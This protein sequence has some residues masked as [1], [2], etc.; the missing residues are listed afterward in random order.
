VA[1]YFGGRWLGR[2]LGLGGETAAYAGA[3]LGV[4]AG[5]WNLFMLVR[6]ID[7]RGGQ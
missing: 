6:R 7:R 3:A 1:G 4:V 5:F 2:L